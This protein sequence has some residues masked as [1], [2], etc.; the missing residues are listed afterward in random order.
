MKKTILAHFS[1][2]KSLS[3]GAITAIVISS[4]MGV[5]AYSAVLLV[6]GRAGYWQSHFGYWLFLSIG[7]WSFDSA[8]LLLLAAL[9]RQLI[10]ANKEAVWIEGD[11]LLY[12]DKRWFAVPLNDIESFAIGSYGR[13]N[14]P[15]VVLELREGA[16]KSIPLG[17][18]YEAGEVVIEC[19]RVANSC[20]THVRQ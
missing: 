12:L 1:A 3:F 7:I 17:P 19:L 16:K 9:F 6:L 14:L 4:I 13:F 5:V 2:T 15:G 18:L 20:A 11:K 8:L 10:F